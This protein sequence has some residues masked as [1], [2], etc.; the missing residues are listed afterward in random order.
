[1]NKRLRLGI[2]AIAVLVGGVAMP[3]GQADEASFRAVPIP[4]EPL[5]WYDEAF[6]QRVIEAGT[7]GVR[8]PAGVTV[9]TALGLAYPGIRPGQ[10]L[11]SV[12]T[13][14]FAWCTANYVFKKR[15]TYGL[16]TAGHCAAK[17]ALAHWPDVTAYVVP[18]PTSGKLP[19]IYHIGKFVLSRD[20]GVGDD[21]A[22]VA[23]YPQYN[24]WMNPTMP[25]WGGPT[26]IKT[27]TSPTVV[28]HFGHGLVVGTGG[29]PRAGVAPIWT[30]RNGDAFA[31]YGVGFQGDSGSAVNTVTQQ[32]GGNFTHIVIYDGSRGDPVGEI[33]PGMLTGTTITKIL[34]IARGWTLQLGSA[35]PL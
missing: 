31:W 28:E 1:M 7:D 13:T 34:Q 33:L 21:F 32:A 17:D 20:N 30:A 14:G 16:G 29:T 12:D 35:V 24:A 10:W 22:M 5:P 25:V 15:S 2:V 19:G 11:I 3:P 4:R 8:V 27:D 18:P 6:H 26:S 9:P 23:I